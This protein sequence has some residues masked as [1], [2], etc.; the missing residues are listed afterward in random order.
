[1]SADERLSAL[2]SQL[3]WVHPPAAFNPQ[4]PDWQKHGACIG[5]DPEWFFPERGDDSRPAKT[6]C[7]AC[8]VQTECLDWAIETQQKFGIW[9]G[10]SERERRQIRSQRKRLAS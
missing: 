1:M 2:P 3:R 10:R 6:I 8:P 9:G 4:R 5:V 7:R